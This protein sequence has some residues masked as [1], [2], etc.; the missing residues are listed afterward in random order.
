MQQAT[1]SFGFITCFIVIL[2]IFTGCYIPIVPYMPVTEHEVRWG[3]GRINNSDWVI[4]VVGRTTREEV[5]L[6]FGEPDAVL[7]EGTILVYTWGREAAV[8]I[9]EMYSH[10]YLFLEFEPD[11]S[12]QRLKKIQKL[13]GGQAN[14]DS[15]KKFFIQYVGEMEFSPMQSS[16]PQP[17]P[18][19]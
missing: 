16:T 1:K 13:L 19:P 10:H 6:Q 9:A 7:N 4:L 3:R 15:V 12:L 8:I 11:G 5:L 14:I 2:L 18:L 17:K